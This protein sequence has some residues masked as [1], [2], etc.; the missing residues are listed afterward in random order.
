[1]SLLER[2]AEGDVEEA[3]EQLNLA[4]ELADASGT[5]LFVD[6]ISSR[7]PPERIATTA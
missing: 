6:L 5:S 1:M 7:A 3:A 4:L 2:G